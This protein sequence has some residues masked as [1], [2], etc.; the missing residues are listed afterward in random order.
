V[1]GLHKIELAKWTYLLFHIK[2][3]NAIDNTSTKKYWQREIKMTIYRA[4]K[5]FDNNP[6]IALKTN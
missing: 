1:K 3:R 5:K 4:L 6:N 2:F